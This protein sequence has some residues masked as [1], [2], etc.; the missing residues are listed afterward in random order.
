MKRW[1][2]RVRGIVGLGTLWGVA[3]S[4]VGAI[5]GI[6]VRLSGGL[7]AGDH[8]VDWILGGGSLGFILGAGFAGV[9]T[10]LEGRRTLDELTPGRAALWGALA[11]ACLPAIWFL[12]FSGTLRSVLSISELIPLLLGAGGAYGA[13]SAGLASAT[14][15]IARRAPS[16]FPSGIAPD[17]MDLLGEPEE[18]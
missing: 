9:L 6:V 16:Q 15:W 1:L 7:P 8:L 2:Q 11:G 12:L 13:L 10:M 3:G 5:A 17:D 18:E 14:V 4:V